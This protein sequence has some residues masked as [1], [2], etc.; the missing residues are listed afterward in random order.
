MTLSLSLNLV[1][2]AALVGTGG[3]LL[4]GMF[5]LGGAL[6]INPLLIALAGIPAPL[7]VGTG[8]CQ[9]IGAATSGI[10]RR[11]HTGT[12]DYAMGLTVAGG[13][14]M[15]VGI[16]VY[17]LEWSKTMGIQ[18]FAGRTVSIADLLVLVLFILLMLFEAAYILW[19]I[20]KH[21]GARPRMG[22]PPL[23]RI[24]LP[25]H[26]EYHGAPGKRLS[27]PAAA[28]LG[29]LTGIL[30]GLLGLGGG[31]ILLPAFVFLAGY[32]TVMAAGTSLLVTWITSLVGGAVHAWH[33]NVHLG[34]LAAILAGSTIG[35][36]IGAS[37]GTRI[38]GPKL[39]RYF[40]VVLVGVSLLS[41]WKIWRLFQAG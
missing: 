16:G 27:I 6:V 9:N 29:V 24:P 7:A 1:V 40:V 14:V 19:D 8:L 22:T 26:V 11:R 35:A 34:L 18:E 5:G 21:P 28:W 2:F 32:R 38:P 3:G 23:G 15:G 41:V 36:Q 10:L 12:V 37:L 33:G 13:S 4:S 39:R 25:P 17:V 31:L 30:G 20:R